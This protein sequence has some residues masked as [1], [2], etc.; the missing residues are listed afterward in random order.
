M[1]AFLSLGEY[2]NLHEAHLYENALQKSE[3]DEHDEA[4]DEVED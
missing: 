2:Y 3:A 1:W 4:G